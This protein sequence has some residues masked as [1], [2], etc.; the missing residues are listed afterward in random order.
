MALGLEYDLLS[1]WTVVATVSWW[2]MSELCTLSDEIFDRWMKLWHFRNGVCVWFACDTVWWIWV[3]IDLAAGHC[4]LIFAKFSMVILLRIGGGGD[5]RSD[6]VCVDT[7]PSVE[8]PFSPEL[9][10]LLLLLI[11]AV[12]RIGTSIL[13]VVRSLEVWNGWWHSDAALL[14]IQIVIASQWFVCLDDDKPKRMRLCTYLNVCL[15]IGSTAMSIR[16][17][18]KKELHEN[19]K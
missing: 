8:W 6:C 17:E 19:Q 4:R 5:A 16:S 11:L 2:L 3:C 10:M 13:Y 14:R 18:K 1:R 15:S 9:V 12:W 7:V